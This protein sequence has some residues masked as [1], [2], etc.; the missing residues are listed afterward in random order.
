MLQ[1]VKPTII[2]L[3]N[4]VAVNSNCNAKGAVYIIKFIIIKIGGN[5]I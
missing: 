2:L 1:P 3:Y 5:N 4:L